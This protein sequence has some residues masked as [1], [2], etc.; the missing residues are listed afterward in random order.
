MKLLFAWLLALRFRIIFQNGSND[1]F[2]LLLELNET[3]PKVSN[4]D[5]SVSNALEFQFNLTKGPTL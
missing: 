4:K 1:D 2:P 3:G 5:G